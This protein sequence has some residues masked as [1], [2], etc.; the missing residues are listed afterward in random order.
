MTGSEELGDCASSTAEN[1]KVMPSDNAKC[2]EYLM[3][4]TLTL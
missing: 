1:T 2:I 3:M 4:L